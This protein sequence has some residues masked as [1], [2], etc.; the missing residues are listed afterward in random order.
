VQLWRTTGCGGWS[1]S[2]KGGTVE[3]TVR[4][5]LQNHFP[6]KLILRKIYIK[7]T[8]DPIYYGLRIFFLFCSWRFIQEKVSSLPRV[9]ASVGIAHATASESIQTISGFQ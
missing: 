1:L 6:K 3:A 5:I 9:E 7:T 2:I 4:T 8:G